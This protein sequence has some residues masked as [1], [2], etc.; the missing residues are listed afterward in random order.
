M[1]QARAQSE[2]GGER[3]RSKTS[4]TSKTSETSEVA[5]RLVGPEFLADR[6]A[7]VRIRAGRVWAAARAEREEMQRRT[8]IRKRQRQRA[9]GPVDPP[10]CPTGWSI[11]PPDFV[12]IGVQKAGTT[13]WHLLL[14]AHPQIQERFPK[15][16][17]Y[18]QYHWLGD[19]DQAAVENY[20][21]YFARPPGWL[22]G[23]WT[24]RYLLDDWTPGQL[25]RAAPD[26]RLLVMLRD[27][28]ERYRSGMTHHLNTGVTLH[29]RF[30]VEAI[31]RGHY[32]LQ[33]DRLLRH[34]PRE[35][36]LMLQYERC[37]ADPSGQLART[38]RF[39]GVEPSFLPDDLSTPVLAAR[40]PKIAMGPERRAELRLEYAD[41]VR[42][43]ADEWPELDM[44][45]WPNFCD[46]AR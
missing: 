9:R 21:R 43:L 6:V 17:H 14:C 40:G 3:R 24:P 34:F 8:R 11:A 23:E 45:L 18:F 42:R 12:G 33:L 46:L 16:L 44:S 15:E 28:V 37:V 22:A 1:S 29:P 31:A 36:V 4:K 27:P 39:L 35:Q 19:F 30:V 26:T 7:S 13:W 41:G 38:Y 5:G 32:R 2:R 20:H 25:R 10:P